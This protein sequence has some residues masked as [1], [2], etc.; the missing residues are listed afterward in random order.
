MIKVYVGVSGC[1]KTTQCLKDMAADPANSVRVNRDS[2]RASVYGLTKESTAEYYARPDLHELEREITRLEDSIIKQ[3]LAEGKNVYADNT[4][5]KRSYIKKYFRFGVPVEIQFIEESKSLLNHRRLQRNDHV[6]SEEL[7]DSQIERYRELRRNWEP[8][9]ASPVFQLDNDQSKGACIIFDLDG[10]LAKMH[11]RT[12]YEFHKVDDDLPNWPVINAI[13]TYQAA[14]FVVGVLSGRD[15]SCL[16][17]SRIWLAGYG[18]YPDFLE[19]RKT[20]DN[21]PDWQVKQEMWKKVCEQYHI[22]A[23]YDDR[24][25]VVARARE[26]G[27]TCFQVDYGNF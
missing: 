14:G 9:V 17:S 10:T 7:L 20:G 11:N 16:K 22:F 13:K 25:Q 2:L 21:R 23:M 4:H 1:G 8:I 24:D 19:L 26:L 3:A 5:L 15:D 27:L 18:I 12:P 6:I